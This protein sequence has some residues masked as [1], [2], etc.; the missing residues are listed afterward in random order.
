MVVLLT[1]FSCAKKEQYNIL[2][3]EKFISLLVQM[4]LIEADFSF[5]GQVDRTSV[6]ANYARY[7]NLFKRYHTDSLQ[8]MNTFNYYEDRQEE[9]RVI[10]KTV[11]DCLNTMAGNSKPVQN[12]VK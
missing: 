4:H 8:V 3:N 1:F 7:K 9:L 11:L 5:N 10:Y 12:P 6:P 2:P